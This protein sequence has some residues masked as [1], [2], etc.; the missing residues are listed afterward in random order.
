MQNNHYNEGHDCIILTC[1]EKT[2]VHIFEKLFE[3]KICFILLIC[4]HLAMNQHVIFFLKPQIYGKYSIISNSAEI[5]A[6]TTIKA[7]QDCY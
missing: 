7:L 3:G 5:A 2:V 6:V 4:F 1:E